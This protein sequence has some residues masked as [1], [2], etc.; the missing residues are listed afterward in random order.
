MNFEIYD[1][2]IDIQK[3]R[4]IEE[5]KKKYKN[6]NIDDYIEKSVNKILESDIDISKI[7]K[8][9][10]KVKPKMIREKGRVNPEKCLARRINLG[11]GGQC[12]WLRINDTDY[13]SRHQTEDS[14]WCGLITEDRQEICYLRG[15][16]PHR[17][18]D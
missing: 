12:T 3:N 7:N 15:I 2:I 4:L 5:F 1:K 6:Y 8:K 18:K 13:C 16:H 17:W 9:Y 14:R 10:K 11:Y